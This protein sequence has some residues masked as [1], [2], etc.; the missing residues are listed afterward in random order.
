MK[1]PLV[2]LLIALWCGGVS[3]D[4]CARWFKNGKIAVGPRCP[5]QCQVLSTGMGT[6]LCP[7]DCEKFCATRPDPKTGLG[8]YLFYPGLTSK[9]KELVAKYPKEALKVF[10]QKEKAQSATYNKFKRDGER[11]ESDAYRHFVWAGFLSKELGPD[12][13]KEFLDA[14]EADSSGDDPD[15][16][17][18]LANNR[19]GLLAA[20]H[21]RKEKRLTDAEIEREAEEALAG[22]TLIVLKPKGAP[23]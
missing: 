3:A 10:I 11:D 21:L 19:A 1:S 13:A 2:T 9:E 15:K 17:M 8:K 18:D 20:E 22:K 4:D 6:F 5:S 14:H 16:A 23:K 12:L 7:R